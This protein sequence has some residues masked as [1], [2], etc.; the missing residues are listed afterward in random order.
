MI[1]VPLLND[2]NEPGLFDK[3]CRQPGKAWLAANPSVD[4]HTQSTWWS[5]FKS[6]LAEHFQHRCGWLAVHIG[7][8]GQVDHW[9]A[10]KTNPQQ[11]FEWSNFRYV[12]GSVNSRKSTLNDQ[13]LDPCEVQEGWFEVHLPSFQLV[14]TT[15]LP[16]T[17]KQRADTTLEQL[18]LR[19]GYEARWTRWDAYR[20]C[21][22]AGSVDLAKLS[23]KAP[24][25]AGA[26]KKAQSNGQPLPDPSETEPPNIIRPRKRPYAKRPTRATQP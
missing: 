22:N 8:Q 2:Q 10:C 15:S 16:I 21:W 7:M 11:A 1:P 14:E 6:A 9:L 12:S 17:H 5:Q 19:N 23:T 24:L 3:N 20:D 13:V 4:P 26:V 18:G 25:V